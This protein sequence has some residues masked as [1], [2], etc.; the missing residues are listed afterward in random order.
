MLELPQD[1][2]ELVQVMNRLNYNPSMVDLQDCFTAQKRYSTGKG[3]MSINIVPF[4]RL[5]FKAYDKDKSGYISS[6]EWSDALNKMSGKTFSE[7]QAKEV[8]KLET[9]DLNNDGKLSFEE[10]VSYIHNTTAELSEDQRKRLK[11]LFPDTLD[12][13]VFFESIG[14]HLTDEELDQINSTCEK[15]ATNGDNLEY[16]FENM[17]KALFMFTAKNNDGFISASE[18]QFLI[19]KIMGGNEMVNV[20]DAMALIAVVDENDDGKLDYREFISMFVKLAEWKENASE[21]G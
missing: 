21:I 3:R 7:N 1:M 17:C 20:E 8:F 10:F 15:E 9:Y 11:A 12:T 18:M 14:I 13:K 5:I 19:G 2:N 16:N 4:V 6:N